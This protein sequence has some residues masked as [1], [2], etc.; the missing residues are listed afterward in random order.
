MKT[1]QLQ[2]AQAACS[3]RQFALT[4]HL[5]MALLALAAAGAQAQTQALQVLHWWKST[6]EHKAIN[7]LAAKLGDDN[8]QWREAVIP[9]GSGIGAAIVLKSRVLSNDAPDVAQMNGIVTLGEWADLGLL[10]EIDQVAASGKWDKLLYPTVLALVQ[11]RGHVV[12]APLGIHRANT[13]FYNR[14]MFGMLGIAPPQT[15][16]EFEQAAVKLQRAGI[17]PLIQSSEPW[18][19][20]TLFETL[21]LAESG[22]GYYGEL[23]VK[24]DPRA[25][26]DARLA[27]A[28]ARLRGLKKW[29][30]APIQEKLWNDTARQFADGAAAMMV[31]G[32][33][34]KGELNAFGLATDGMFSCVP[35][36]ETG[37]Y[38]LYI[39]DTLAMLG[40]DGTRRPAQ[41]KLAQ[42]VMSPA[43]QAEYSQVKGSIPVLRNPDLSRMDSWSRAS[44]KLFSRGAAWQAPSLTH[45]MAT[46]ESSKDAIIAEVH[47]FFMNEQ[48]SVADAQRRLGQIASTLVKK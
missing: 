48:I 25:F 18:Q 11:P 40:T 47:R 27:H 41:E 24:K 21:V 2:T 13:L 32:D 16:D 9:G 17:A 23:F 22:P 45:R 44:W 8:I 33:F 6:S 30:A 10:L 14:R 35:V 46:D 36:P 42:I 28:L 43:G 26:A 37:N 5:L 3:Y 34:M 12:A 29:M 20:A 7:V 31:M 1:R 15:W 38:H 19:V 4:R 39:I